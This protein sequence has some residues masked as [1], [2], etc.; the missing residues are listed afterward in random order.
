[1]D[2]IS[3]IIEQIVNYMGTFGFLGGFLLVLLES[4]FPPIPLGVIVGINMLS[5]GKV[6]GFLLSYIAT[7]TGCI[8]SFFLF[9]HLFKDKFL[10]LFSK[11]NQTS[12]NKWMEK[13]TNIDFNTLV[14]IMAL[15]ITPS[16]LVNIAGGLSNISYR[17]YLIAMM[18]GKP[19][20]LLFYGYIA[21]SFV[22][23]LKDPMNF[24]KIGALV[25]GAYLISKIIERVVKVEK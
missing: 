21:V 6:F 4:V 16:F 24:I 1:M 15:P 13:L 25:F 19:A 23:S 18:I 22:E 20:M 7:L 11:K 3:L 2:N 5:F 10:H 8:A 17:K 14:V 12:I 9:R